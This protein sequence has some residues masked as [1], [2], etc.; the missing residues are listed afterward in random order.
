MTYILSMTVN[1]YLCRHKYDKDQVSQGIQLAS[2]FSKEE[3]LPRVYGH[4][5]E[6]IEAYRQMTAHLATKNEKKLYA[7]I[8][9]CDFIIVEGGRGHSLNLDM[10]DLLAKVRGLD[11]YYDF[12]LKLLRGAE[13]C[14]G[15]SGEEERL[16]WA[17]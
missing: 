14:A 17:R 16:R 8:S 6:F 5:F 4:V 15:R 2:Q 1:H 3:T 7:F 13:V 9:N 10:L 11:L 12:L